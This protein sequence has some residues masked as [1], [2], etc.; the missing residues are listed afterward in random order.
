[1]PALTDLGVDAGI[2]CR[3]EEGADVSLFSDNMEC[4]LRTMSINHYY[5][6]PKL[7]YIDFGKIDTF[8]FDTGFDEARCEH[9]IGVLSLFPRLRTLKARCNMA[10]GQLTP[11]TMPDIK[12][13]TMEISTRVRPL[14][15]C[16]TAPRLQHLSFINIWVPTKSPFGFL[17]TLSVGF[18]Q[19][20]VVPLMEF[21]CAHTNLVALHISP[22]SLS[23][24]TVLNRLNGQLS[25]PRIRP[26]GI[27]CPSLEF[28]RLSS[29]E[30]YNISNPFDVDVRGIIN[31]LRP[32][33]EQRP[34]L[35]VELA[36][37]RSHDKEI[38]YADQR[39]LAAIVA[40][41]GTRVSMVEH[42]DH[43][44]PLSELFP[45]SDDYD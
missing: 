36:H 33:L 8:T 35:T 44:V 1:M 30:C 5:P 18:I 37:E 7:E 13:I 19:S 27:P 15:D 24:L 25:T 9:V 23:I 43:L 42:V 20:E 12:D 28:L 10:A 16:I 32:L 31:A 41:V 2:F 22:G 11:I 6:F 17:R 4:R 40:E 45:T 34:T 39:W 26:G 3:R 21:V 14:L 38:Y 29:V